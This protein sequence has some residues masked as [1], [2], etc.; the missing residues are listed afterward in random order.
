MTTLFYFLLLFQLDIVKHNRRLK[1]N[2]CLT[3]LKIV[4][5]RTNFNEPS[6]ES[7][8]SVP[9]RHISEGPARTVL[10]PARLSSALSELFIYIYKIKLF[11]QN[12]NF[13]ICF[14]LQNVIAVFV[15]SDSRCKN[16]CN[17]LQICAHVF[18][19]RPQNCA[20]ISIRSRAGL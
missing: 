2:K 4:W 11:F 5:Y 6:W 12:F 13:F 8:R 3:A 9:A 10:S 14:Y 20:R 17:C 18:I 19:K 15:F 1:N 16:V 7:M